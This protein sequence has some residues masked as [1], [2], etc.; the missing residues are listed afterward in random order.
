MSWA[1][2]ATIQQ[3]IDSQMK[4]IRLIKWVG[5]I[6]RRSLHATMPFNNCTDS[7]RKCKTK[8]TA[9]PKPDESRKSRKWTNRQAFR[10]PEPTK[11]LSRATTKITFH[12][13]SIRMGRSVWCALFIGQMDLMAA[14]RVVRAWHLHEKY[15]SEY[16]ALHSATVS[17]SDRFSQSSPI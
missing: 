13:L 12:V 8:G 2:R 14:V 4:M 5:R 15:S 9:E 11:K 10:W 7:F 3:S 6:R 1:E 17:W 16:V